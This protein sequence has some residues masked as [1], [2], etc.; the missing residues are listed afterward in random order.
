MTERYRLAGSTATEIV[1]SLER[2]VRDGGLVAGD[3][4]P[5]VRGL[6]TELGVAPGTVASAYKTAAARGLVETRGRLGTRVRARPAL[7]TRSSGPAV[8]SGVVDLASGQ[9][10][11]ALLP[12]LDTVDLR[13]ADPAE[14]PGDLVLPELA[15]LAR[16]RLA[17][18]GVDATHLT[19]AAGGLDAIRRILL[20]RLA[21]GDAVA[22]EDPGWPNLLDLLAASGLRAL[23]VRVDEAGP[24]PRALATA[25]S[26]GARAVVVTTRAQNPTGAAVTPARA[27]RLRSVLDAHP[28][29]LL[30]E[31][32]H[33]AE[34]AR[35]P[36]ASLAGSTSAWAFVRSLSKP[37]GPD[38]R[39]A[40]VVGDEA[41]TAR[42]EG[43]L[44]VGSGWVSTLLQRLAVALWSDPEVARVVEVAADTYD[45]RRT[46]LLR[47]LDDVG[48][49]GTGATGLNV[50]VPVPDEARAVAA[51]LAA[52]WAVAP[53]QR[54][55]QDA[56]PAVRVT[57]GDLDEAAAVELATA[58]R[59]AVR[60]TSG[61][62]VTA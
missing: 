19:L 13:W 16:R 52:G 48:V 61:G 47:A 53:G 42:V 21:P 25:L 50:W 5:T 60:G 31:D 46:A 14:A 36:L 10:S 56:G 26:D 49:P 30:V 29:V 58:L 7:A 12:R 43:Q 22:V 2:A 8:P 41:T 4:L 24:D 37:Y 9:P 62:P 40:V 20:A 27:A 3:L 32:D 28:D 55:R 18:A 34:L 51:L 1:A 35:V 6:A 23:P 33:A 59:E 54:F 45:A 57:V 17:A 44:R 11:A 38:L 39:L 15:D